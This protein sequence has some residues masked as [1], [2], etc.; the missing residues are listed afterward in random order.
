MSQTT[1]N[2]GAKDPGAV[3]TVKTYATEVAAQ[4]AAACLE[5]N[6]IR[7]QLAADDCGG[8]LSAMDNYSGVKLIVAAADATAAR[9]ILGLEGVPEPVPEGVEPRGKSAAKELKPSSKSSGRPFLLIVAFLL[10]VAATLTWGWLERVGTRTHESDTYGDG[11]VDHREI[12]RNG[13]L[14]ET[15][16]DRNGDG[17]MDDWASYDG[18][19]PVRSAVDENFDGRV[20]AWTTFVRRFPSESQLDTDSNGVPDVTIT[21]KFGQTVRADYQPNGTN[22][23]TVR[24]LYE[25]G[26]LVEELR[27][28]DWD[29]YFDVSVKYDALLNPIQTNYLRL[30]SAPKPSK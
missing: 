7:C 25:N 22:V 12:W 17:R 8:M 19:L 2:G 13:H 15:E 18:G 24:D 1:N 27:D 20:D 5:A 23:V 28:T 29:G 11:R 16:D 9:D 21:Y 14:V 26:L 3:V 4:A 10:G 30:L 6:G